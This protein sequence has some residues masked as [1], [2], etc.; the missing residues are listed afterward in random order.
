MIKGMIFDLDGTILDSMEVW[1]NIDIEFLGK[2]GLAV[3]DDYLEAITPMGFLNAAIYTKE[4]FGFPESPEEIEEEWLR[5]AEYDYA[6]KVELK[7]CAKEFL[8]KCKAEGIKLAVATSSL[9]RL[10]VPCLQHH[11]LC[12]LFEIAVTTRQAGADKKSPRVYQM[13]ADALGLKPE[14]CVVFEDIVEGIRTAKAADFYAVG[15]YDVH[16]DRDR[17]NMVALADRYLMSYEEV[18]TED[19]ATFLG[20]MKGNI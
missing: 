10:F 17:N 6:N 13:A 8:L 4:R 14:E 2:R 15:V 1:R 19:V 16:S 7:P 11:D 9:E 20:K 3:P 5:M 18:A 12:D